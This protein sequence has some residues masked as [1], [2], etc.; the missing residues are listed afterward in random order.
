M[1]NLRSVAVL[2]L[3]A[4][5]SV[6]MVLSGCNQGRGTRSDASSVAPAAEV[7]KWH[8]TEIPL[9]VDHIENPPGYES[10]DWALTDGFWKSTSTSK[11]KQLVEVIA[12]KISCDRE[13]KKCREA[14]AS[15]FL[16]VLDAQLTEYEVASW[17]KDG[18]VADDS[19]KCN[20]HTL[21]IDFKAN[22]VTVTDYPLK[23]SRG[24]SVCKPLHDAYSYALHG[25]QLQLFPPPPSGVTSEK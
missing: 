4:A 2:M 14:D 19:D 8:V 24:D 3:L 25:G 12:V 7:P 9:T 5:G 18:I 11:D 6:T 16:G 13:E 1:K 23:Q 22:S 10:Y 17:T 20:R 21:A 15:M